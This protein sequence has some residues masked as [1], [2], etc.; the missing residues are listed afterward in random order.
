[1]KT[2]ELK[3]LTDALLEQLPI[4]VILTD[5]EGNITLVNKMAE[6][7]RHILRDNVLGHNVRLAIWKSQKPT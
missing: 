5:T 3:T 2:D 6:R 7:I 1:M 4:G